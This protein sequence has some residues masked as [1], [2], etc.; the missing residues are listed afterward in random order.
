MQFHMRLIT[1]AVAAVVVCAGQ[2]AAQQPSCPITVD[3]KNLGP[4][5]YQ[6]RGSRCEG[7]TA[8]PAGGDLIRVI[9]LTG[10]VE[11]FNPQLGADLH[12]TWHALPGDSVWLKSVG[13]RPR[14]FYQM[15]ASLPPAA[16]EFPW[17]VSVLLGENIRQKDIAVRGWTSQSFGGIRET[18]LLPV[19]I[20][21]QQA[22]T[23][24]TPD[25]MLTVLPTVRLG[26]L[27]WGLAKTDS[28]GRPAGWVR[29]MAS[30]SGTDFMEGAAVHIPLGPM[31]SP[32]LFRLQLAGDLWTTT[33]VAS[34]D[35]V[36][37]TATALI[38]IARP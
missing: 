17:P 2:L 8:R 3:L 22:S 36:R 25:Y 12:V 19:T 11:N 4:D 28:L 16:R 31:T 14:L 37:P 32:G 23:S 6:P 34:K 33:G 5:A 26:A 27:R 10:T 18:V 35:S 20:S 24:P 1:R 15:D 29:E 38:R 13:I 9:G 21:Q 30:V 7:I